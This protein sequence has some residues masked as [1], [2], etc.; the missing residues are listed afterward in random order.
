MVHSERAG[1]TSYLHQ[2]APCLDILFEGLVFRLVP[3][4]GDEVESTV[5]QKAIGGACLADDIDDN[6]ESG[7]K[8]SLEEMQTESDQQR[9]SAIVAMQHVIRYSLNH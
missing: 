4:A 2:A 8:R 5:F 7:R 3:F 6:A 1:N 9:Y